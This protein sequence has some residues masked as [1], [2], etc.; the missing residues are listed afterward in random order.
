[1]KF[2]IGLAYKKKFQAS[3]GLIDDCSLFI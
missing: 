1:M 3:N 2:G